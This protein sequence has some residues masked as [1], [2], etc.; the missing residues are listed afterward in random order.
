VS[1]FMKHPMIELILCPYI[2]LLSPHPVGVH[3]WKSKAGKEG[4]KPLQENVDGA[5]FVHDFDR[6]MVWLMKYLTKIL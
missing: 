4:L 3:H 1:I 2:L 6:T 5:F